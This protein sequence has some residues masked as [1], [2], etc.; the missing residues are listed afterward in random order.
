MRNN[1]VAH[2]KQPGTPGADED[3]VMNQA[4]NIGLA[5]RGFDRK[6]RNVRVVNRNVAH[7]SRSGRPAGSAP[8]GVQPLSPGDSDAAAGGPM[9]QKQGGANATG[10]DGNST[11]GGGSVG[12]G[13]GAAA[14]NA[15]GTPLGDAVRVGAPANFAASLQQ[16]LPGSKIAD[17]IAAEIQAGRN[18]ADVLGFHNNASSGGANA[19]A[20]GGAGGSSNNSNNGGNGSVAGGNSNGGVVAAC[21]SGSPCTANA[22]RV[23][24]RLIGGR[25]FVKTAAPPAVPSEEERAARDLI[26]RDPEAQSIAARLRDARGQLASSE[27]AAA[28]LRVLVEQKTAELGAAR[29]Q[30]RALRPEIRALDRQLRMRLHHVAGT[31]FHK[32]IHQARSAA[33]VRAPPLLSASVSGGG[34]M[35]TCMRVCEYL[36]D[37]GRSNWRRSG[38]SSRRRCARWARSPCATRRGWWRRS[39]RSEDAGDGAVVCLR[40]YELCER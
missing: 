7:L 1:N 9:R 27:Q 4:Q 12:G 16:V 36:C 32:Q 38:A 11:N 3:V 24:K 6:P 8:A 10:A 40:M 34:R 28:A 31:L 21:A 35:H 15:S 39:F 22:T 5:H 2:L 19:S 33:Q 20:A 14:G 29:S 23:V 37:R 18:P 17:R 30:I 26:Q 25:P 13:A